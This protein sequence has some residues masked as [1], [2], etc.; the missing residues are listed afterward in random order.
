MRVTFAALL[1]ALTACAPGDP[2]KD[3]TPTP[4][5]RDKVTGAEII[6]GRFGADA[7]EGGCS[8]LEA[9]DGTHYE[10][11]Y[12]DGWQVQA[13]PLQLTDPHG[14]VVATGGE[15]ITVRGAVAHEMASICQIGPIFRATEVVAID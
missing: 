14:E 12:P 10:V 4:S 3:E 5:T 9:D 15:M 11:I 1:I 13:S 8:H 2:G 6:T 7:V